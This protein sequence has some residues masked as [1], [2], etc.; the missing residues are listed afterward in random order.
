M[1][2]RLAYRCAFF[3]ASRFSSV[4]CCPTAI[5]QSSG[6]AIVRSFS[7]FSSVLSV[8]LFCP[9]FTL[10]VLVFAVWRR[11]GA[12]RRNALLS[13]EHWILTSPAL[14]FGVWLFC[15]LAMLQ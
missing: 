2:S 1:F 6:K 8:I 9:F 3:A 11:L 10:M 5:C 12:K 13:E 15:L 4:T 14:L 7:A